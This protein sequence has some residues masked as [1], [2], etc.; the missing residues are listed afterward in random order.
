MLYDEYDEEKEDDKVFM[1]R[2]KGIQ[3]KFEKDLIKWLFNIKR[4]VIDNYNNILQ[5]ICTD[6]TLLEQK[7]LI[8]I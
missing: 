8:N 5:S 2:A 3:E 7:K 1:E 4:D 6:K